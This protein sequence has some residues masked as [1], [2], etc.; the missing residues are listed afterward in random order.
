VK[1]T[2]ANYSETSYTTEREQDRKRRYVKK[3][4]FPC[5]GNYKKNERCGYTDDGFIW[6]GVYLEEH[7]L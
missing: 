3:L 4:T 6:S 7:S 2:E 5:Q 1:K